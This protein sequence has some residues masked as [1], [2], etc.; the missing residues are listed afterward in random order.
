VETLGI[1]PVRHITA[2]AVSQRAQF[3]GEASVHAVIL[4]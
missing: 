1:T 2:H 3:C 4:K